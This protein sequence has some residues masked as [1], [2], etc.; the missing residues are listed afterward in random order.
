MFPEIGYVIVQAVLCIS[1][2]T[3]LALKNGTG[4]RAKHGVNTD[5][6]KSTWLRKT[7]RDKTRYKLVCYIIN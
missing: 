6:I 4:N 7:L 5:N 1:Q 3:N 2:T